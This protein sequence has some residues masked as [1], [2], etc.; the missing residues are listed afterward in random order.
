MYLEK[1]GMKLGSRLLWGIQY[2]EINLQYGHV[3]HF[4]G[5]RKD[6]GRILVKMQILILHV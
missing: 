4:P 1:T 2:I 3:S 6:S 5:H